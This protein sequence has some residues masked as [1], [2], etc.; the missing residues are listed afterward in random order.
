MI[1]L[2]S[3][4]VLLL[5]PLAMLILRL[6]RPRFGFFWL[7]A[8]S[9]AILAWALLLFSR[10]RMP[11]SFPL[12]TWRPEE[13]FPVSPEL[14]VDGVSWPFALALAT[15]A[16]AGIL[17]DV[18][19]KPQDEE[20]I[21]NWL[22]WSSGLAL[23]GLG[24][25]AILAGNLLTVLLAWTALDL[26]EIIIWL[27]QVQASEGR[28]Q[29]VVAFAGRLA[30]TVGVLW[31]SMLAH[32]AYLPLSLVTIPP[33]IST[34][35]LVAA[36]LRLGI[37]PASS[38]LSQYS[39]SW[40]SQAVLLRLVPVAA[41]LPLLVR[42]ASVGAAPAWLPYLFLVAALAA[43]YGGVSWAAASDEHSAQ[44]YWTLGLAS[45]ALA[46]ALRA[47][48]AAS[49]AW[50]LA[51]L[52]PGG[53]LLLAALRNRG[54]T[55]LLLVGWLG[56]SG[57]PFTPAWQGMGLYHA[58]FP[59]LGILFLLAHAALSAGY[60]RHTLR[61]APP[62]AGVERWVW[63]I[64][65][66]GLFLPVVVHLALAWWGRIPIPDWVDSWPGVLSNAL[67]VAFAVWRGRGHKVSPRLQS[68]VSRF[69]SIAWLYRLL[70]NIYYAMRRASFFA[71]AV[72]EGRAGSLWALLLLILLLSLL[73]Q[74]TMG[75]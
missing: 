27:S 16:M 18:V 67:A 75:G 39:P 71:S 63:L 69:L 66:W 5:A 31:A 21:S 53:L 26:V 49:L 47:Q 41:I 14:L 72:L 74:L 17:T 33:Q 44:S 3:I 4:L 6:V 12:V 2:F 57:L 15:L 29:A 20:G 59:L 50:G 35:L 48:P 37:F 58:P 62:L 51:A 60:L 11:F 32:A 55:L 38:P 54:L 34:Y 46:S 22:A 28:E 61:P 7:L 40:R 9:A 1:A 19:R 30:G 64:Y 43:L 52:L 24:L 8:A 45:L 36:G 13:F 56:M 73:F 70:W 23:A 42:C 68:G 25:L 10:L 65:P